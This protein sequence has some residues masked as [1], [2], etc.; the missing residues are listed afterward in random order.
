MLKRNNSHMEALLK[1]LL[2]Y[3]LVLDEPKFARM[4]PVFLPEVYEDMVAMYRPL[5]EAK[6]LEMKAESDPVLMTVISH[7]TKIVQIVSNLLS[8]AIKYTPSGTVHLSFR[9]VDEARWSV[10]VEDT[11]PG[12]APE[13]RDQI[14]TEFHR[15]RKTA[16]VEGTGLGLALVKRLA[17]LLGGEVH[18]E[19]EVGQGSRFEVILPRLPKTSDAAAA[20]S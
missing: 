17:D 8:N 20:E 2:N 15:L 3:T 1:D 18:L 9:S 10:V 16:H 5:A 14:F 6:G 19:S 12:I 7:R 4:E 11:G 13:E